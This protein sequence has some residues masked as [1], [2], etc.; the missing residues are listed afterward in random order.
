M[1]A[2][3]SPSEGDAHRAAR[4]LARAVRLRCPNCG[5][6]DVFRRFGELRPDCPTCGLQLDRG[7]PDYFLGAYVLNLAAVEMLFAAMLCT[8][9]VATWPDPPWAW[10]QW[11][12]AA[13]MIVGAVVCYPF[14][15]TFWLAIDLTLRPVERDELPGPLDL[16]LQRERR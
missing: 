10:V 4:H 12:G 13:L 16:P 7:E 6:G 11:G 9:V 15:K 2:V 3:A 1:T 5:G 8:V 14:A